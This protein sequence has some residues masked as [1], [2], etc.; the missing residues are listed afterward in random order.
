[1]NSIMYRKVK[2]LANNMF[3]KENIGRLSISTKDKPLV[4]LSAIAKLIV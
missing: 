1:M 2:T 4:N 3:N